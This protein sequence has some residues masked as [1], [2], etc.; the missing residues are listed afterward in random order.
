MGISRWPNHISLFN[1]QADGEPKLASE[2]RYMLLWLAAVDYLL[3]FL[4]QTL[5]GLLWGI[6]LDESG[7][8]AQNLCQGPISN[9]S[10]IGWAASFQPER[11][12]RSKAA[13]LWRGAVAG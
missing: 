13:I 4:E 11:R 7:V 8:G 2:R 3:H 10:P 6:A 5:T 1:S 12:L 9:A